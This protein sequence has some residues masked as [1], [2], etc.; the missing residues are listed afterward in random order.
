MIFD[1]D[2]PHEIMWKSILIVISSTLLLYGNYLVYITWNISFGETLDS[3]REAFVLFMYL[4]DIIIAGLLTIG[5][6]GLLV[7]LI[8]V[9]VDKL[10]GS[11]DNYFNNIK[12][13]KLQRVLRQEEKTRILNLPRTEK[14]LSKVGLA[15]KQ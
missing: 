12:A 2:S 15:K 11:V 14:F 13:R 5:I 1:H 9:G 10:N 6:I 3:W 7:E 8:K 4:V